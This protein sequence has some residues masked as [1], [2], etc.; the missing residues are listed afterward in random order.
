MFNCTTYSYRSPWHSCSPRQGVLHSQFVPWALH[1]RTILKHLRSDGV[2]LS[3]PI[4]SLT[5]NN[6][7]HTHSHTHTLHIYTQRTRSREGERLTHMLLPICLHFCYF[8]HYNSLFSSI[9]FAETWPQSVQHYRNIL[10]LWLWLPYILWQQSSLARLIH[11]VLSCKCKHMQTLKK[12]LC[13]NQL[14]YIYIHLKTC[15]LQHPYFSFVTN[16]KS[17]SYS[18]RQA[19]TKYTIKGQPPIQHSNFEFILT[20]HVTDAAAGITCIIHSTD[21]LRKRWTRS[22]F[23]FQ[24]A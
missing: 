10:F 21:T 12:T 11:V 9:S 14:N 6:S 13:F 16:D 3:V 17:H 19:T 2:F 5:K 18:T 23:Y 8:T 15:F 1:L 7:T 4:T 20:T 22:L 24:I